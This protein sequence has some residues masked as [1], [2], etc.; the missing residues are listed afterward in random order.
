[1]MAGTSGSTITIPP[2]ENTTTT[3]T[4]TDTP[5]T[6]TTTTVPVYYYNV[7]QVNCPGCTTF[8]AGIL[9]V[10]TILLANGDYYNIGDGFVYLVN[11]GTGAGIPVVDLSGSATAGNDCSGTCAL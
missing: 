2:A 4:T 8:A 5:T 6:T 7:D 11:F 3:T 10:S 1:L 9:A